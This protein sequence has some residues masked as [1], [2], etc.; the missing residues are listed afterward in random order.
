MNWHA[1]LPWILLAAWVWAVAGIWVLAM[2]LLAMLSGW[3]RL[4]AR[5]R[6]STP[7]P[8]TKW[9]IRTGAMRLYMK[10]NYGNCLRV[11]VSDKGLGLWIVWLFQMGH[12]PLLIPWSEIVASQDRLWF[13]IRC[14]RFTFPAEPAVTLW[15][16]TRLAGKTQQALGQDWF[17]V[18][19]GSEPAA[20]S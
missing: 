6:C 1:L 13:F 3:K 10:T 20:E 12:P 16:T 4:A 19:A 15:L 2:G 7:L 8:G 9:R 11:T 5:Y 17:P 18:P 14:V